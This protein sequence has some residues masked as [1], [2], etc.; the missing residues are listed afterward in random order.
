MSI[1][2][3]KGKQKQK[4]NARINSLIIRIKY[5][6]IYK[7]KQLLILWILRHNGFSKSDNN[8]HN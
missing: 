5:L 7:L 8:V 2:W 6:H 3:L 1:D 4:W